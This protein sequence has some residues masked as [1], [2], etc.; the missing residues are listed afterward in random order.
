MIERFTAGMDF[1]AFREDAKAVAAVERKLLVISEA[2]IR[3]GDVAAVLCPDQPW[4][5]IRGL[6]NW[7]RHQYERIDLDS[8]WGTVQHDLPVLKAAVERALSKSR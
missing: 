6:G 4:H 7:I 3:T 1:Q 8:I 2:A 5:K